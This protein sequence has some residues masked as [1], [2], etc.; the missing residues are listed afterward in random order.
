MFILFGKGVNQQSKAN[1][2]GCEQYATQP[3]IIN[4][5]FSKALIHV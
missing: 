4:P 2:L 1:L 3:C 5:C